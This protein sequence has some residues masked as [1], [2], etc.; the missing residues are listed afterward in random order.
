[1]ARTVIFLAGILL[2]LGALP[3]RAGS[4]VVGVEDLAYLPHYGAEN[5]EYSGL[6]R[7]ILDTFAKDNGHTLTY[8]PL[9]ITRLYQSLLDGRIDF[10]YPDSPTW[11]QSL[12]E[13]HSVLYSSP[14]VSYTDGV[15]VK[16][17]NLGKGVAAIKRLGTVKGFTPWAW[18]D[19]VESKEVELS[20][21]PSFTGLMRQALSGRI[22]GAY[23]NVDVARHQLHDVIGSPGGL[24]ADPALPSVRDFY[25]LSTTTQPDVLRQFDAWLSANQG[26]IASLKARWDLP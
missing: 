5:G 19:R 25:F 17:E 4:Y 6:V 13:G 2:A 8:L 18:M 21:N 24:V 20:E 26:L 7:D 9:P 11:K 12:K 16:P 22:D 3:A 1:M 10:K 15:M 23:I 14:V